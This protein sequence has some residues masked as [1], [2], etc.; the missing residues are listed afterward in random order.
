MPTLNIEGRKVTVDDSFLSLTPE[1]QNATVDEISTSINQSQQRQQDSTYDIARTGLG[2]ILEGVPIAGPYLREGADM[3]SAGIIAATGPETYDEVREQ[4]SNDKTR[5]KQENPKTNFA[6]NVVGAVVGTAPLIAAAPALF[7]AGGGGLL[8][9]TAASAGSGLALSVAD[10]A[11]R[12]DGDID[13]MKQSGYWGLGLSALGPVAG[14]V[15]GAGVRGASNKI[16]TWLQPNNLGFDDAVI[17][18]VGRA[19]MDDGLDASTAAAR[20]K[21]L[22]PDAMLMDLGPN[23]KQQAGA[24]VATPNRGQEIIK[25]AVNARNASSSQRITSA[26]DETLGKAKVPSE[27]TSQINANKAALSDAYEAVFANSKDVDLVHLNKVLKSAGMAKRG[28]AQTMARNLRKMLFVA[29]GGKDKILTKDPLTLFEIRQAIDGKSATAKNPK[30]KALLTR[31]R[32]FVDEELSKKVPNIKKIDAQYEQ[33]AIQ[34]EALAR[35]QQVLESGRTA[36][37]PSELAKE[38]SEG[39]Q[40]NGKLVGPSAVSF[41]LSQGARAE[42]ERIVGNN[43][44]DRVAL[45]RIVKGEGDWNRSRLVS[46][47]GDSRTDKILGVL[48]AEKVFADTSHIVTGNSQTAA[49]QAAMSE[50][51]PSATKDISMQD[52]YAFGGG[53]GAARALGLKAANKIIQ[54]MG[55]N[56]QSVNNQQLADILTSGNREQIVEILTRANGGVKIDASKVDEIVSTVLL[57]LGVN[58]GRPQ[59]IPSP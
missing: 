43:A 3:L 9:S 55:S 29:D 33:L 8:V 57:G 48:D 40:P 10:T 37:R 41:R 51:N 59:T 12:T 1:A 44:N 36:P 25:S 22:G 50:V 13:A 56:R 21:E 32:K 53:M 20:M 30:V 14:K 47:F 54:S 26:L 46:L 15:V 42:I 28:P 16:A 24:L 58:S 19:A 5:L 7:G 11:V 31:V 38:V 6:G 18:K 17:S 35:G 49:R 52:A 45:Q 27:I 34:D 4:L 2:G 39:V 23:L